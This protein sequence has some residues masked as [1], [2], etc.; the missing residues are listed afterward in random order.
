MTAPAVQPATARRVL[1]AV[2]S[3]VLDHPENE[4]LTL[5][6]HLP[7]LLVA[8]FD[9]AA[10][11]LTL[12]ASVAGQADPGR[13]QLLVVAEALPHHSLPQRLHVIGQLRQALDA[14]RSGFDPAPDRLAVLMDAVNAVIT[15]LELGGA[16]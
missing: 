8:A 12:T 14:A 2:A 5:A 6:L 9:D 10:A 11:M 7:E 1:G 13:F 15:S 4:G 3:L 16:S